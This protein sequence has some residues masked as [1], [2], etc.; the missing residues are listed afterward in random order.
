MTFNG[1]KQ[2]ASETKL[3]LHEAALVAELSE[4]GNNP[5][6]TRAQLGEF[7][8]VILEESEKQFGKVQETLTGN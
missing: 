5:E 8:R 4:T 7:L 3:P 1:I 2:M 6:E